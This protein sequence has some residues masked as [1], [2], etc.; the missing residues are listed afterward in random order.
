MPTPRAHVVR[1]P[2]HGYV[3]VPGE[4]GPLVAS[5]AVQRLRYVAQTARA[6]VRYPSLTGTRFEHALGTM[7]LAL[8]GW[9]EAWAHCSPAAG[10]DA[11]AVRAAFV[12]DVVGDLAREPDPDP[13]TAAWLD[14]VRAGGRDGTEAFAHGVG[15]ALGAVGLLHDVGH[16]PFSHIL[17]PFYA[18][19]VPEVFGADGAAGFE[20]YEKA[21]AHGAQFHEWAGLAIV[22]RLPDAAFAHLPRLLVR[23]LLADRSGTGWADALHGLV[24]GQF[25][26]D[27][28][29]YLMRDADRA[30]TEF[31]AIDHERLLSSLELHRS[32]SRGWAVGLGAR[33]IS[34][35]ETLLVQRAQLYRWVNH[36]HAVVAA[37]TAL[38]RCVGAVHHL[39]TRPPA[40]A[41]SATHEP[42]ATL[43]AALP[44][45][46]YVAAATDPASGA[47]TDDL[48][49]LGWLRSAVPALGR[50]A[51]QTDD[52]ALARRA[53]TALRLH[54]LADTFSVTAVPA[55]RNYQ[56]LLARAGQNPD[57]VG[58]VV[59]AAPPARV[60]DHLLTAPA[61]EAYAA[62]SGEVSARLNEALDALLLAG[63]GTP[64]D[65]EERLGALAGEVPGLG[66]GFWLLARL[67]FLAVKEEFA[68]VWRG[69]D[70]SP[71]SAVSP[72]PLALT[73]I[74]A[75]RPRWMVFFV[76]FEG[77]ADDTDKHARR[78]VGRVLLDTLA[79]RVRGSVLSR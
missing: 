48:A 56:E 67:P 59:A 24:D 9:R 66:E 74:E 21:C 34:A 63:G 58:T 37:D 50:L 27:R 17:E 51:E 69:D 6:V 22:D 20:A 31:G 23:R 10:E 38:R 5:A 77:A 70:E 11:D 44:D 36:H 4:L 43:R 18:A 72:F 45:L 79:A 33:A 28:L 26:V 39:S 15:L 13:V 55:W 73:A 42:L 60:P 65:A 12:R 8:R 78:E 40:A 71:L 29:D 7:H 53:R 75:M 49:L 1:D 62:L 64:E 16:P 25:D 32:A 68:T 41:G 3:E 30:G 47:C 61:R 57:A 2:V 14:A 19:R 54:G 46:D 35:F 76:P 52:A